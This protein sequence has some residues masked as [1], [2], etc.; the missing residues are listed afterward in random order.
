[1]RAWPKCAGATGPLCPGE[2][3]LASLVCSIVFHSLL[4]HPFGTLGKSS[5]PFFSP[6]L[7]K[8]WTAFPGFCISGE[9]CHWRPIES[10]KFCLKFVSA[11]ASSSIVEPY[12]TIYY[13]SSRFFG[14]FLVFGFL[15]LPNI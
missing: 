12:I 7:A 1:M 4:G 9:S 10:P 11:E 13:L 3:A 5:A 15:V 6:L 8:T 14:V 2:A